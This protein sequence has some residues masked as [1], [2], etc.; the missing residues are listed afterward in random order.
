MPFLHGVQCLHCSKMTWRCGDVVHF[1][2]NLSLQIEGAATGERRETGWDFNREGEGFQGT[3]DP[4]R[5][6][7]W[8]FEICDS[9]TCKQASHLNAR[10]VFRVKIS[11]MV[12]EYGLIELLYLWVDS[13]IRGVCVDIFV[14]NIVTPCILARSFRMCVQE[15]P[16]GSLSYIMVPSS[17]SVTPM[18]WK[19]LNR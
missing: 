19:S 18:P 12:H 16:S 15:T 8:T 4:R 17:I 13:C 3:M 7:R 5:D 10:P 14:H 11:L 6:H 1:P 9:L 2:G